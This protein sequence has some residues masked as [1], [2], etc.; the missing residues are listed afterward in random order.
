MQNESDF[1]AAGDEKTG[2]GVSDFR[3]LTPRQY[4]LEPQS[5]H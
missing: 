5:V 3:K 2:W 4:D 1:D